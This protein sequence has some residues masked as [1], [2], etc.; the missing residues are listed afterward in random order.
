[1]DLTN[2]RNLLCKRKTIALHKQDMLTI[3][4][5]VD[6]SKRIYLLEVSENMVNTIRNFK[7]YQLYTFNEIEFLQLAKFF[8]ERNYSIMDVKFIGCDLLV[9][10]AV[11]KQHAHAS[12]YRSG[13]ID[14]NIDMTANIIEFFNNK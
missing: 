11:D 4:I 13:M 10:F 5:Y 14:T 3:P 6:E 12:L 1:M 8:I 2:Q 7:G 9:S